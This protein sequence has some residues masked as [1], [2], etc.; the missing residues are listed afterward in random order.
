MNHRGKAIGNVSSHVD[1]ATQNTFSKRGRT[2]WNAIINK[3]KTKHNFIN[4]RGKATQNAISNKDISALKI[5]S[6][7]GNPT[8]LLSIPGEMKHGMSSVK[9][10]KLYRTPTEVNLYIHQ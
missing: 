10:V 1:K 9:R 2:M 3:R 6:I 8:Y 5:I 7:I 4:K